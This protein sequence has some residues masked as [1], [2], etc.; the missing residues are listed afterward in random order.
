MV[1]RLIRTAL[2]AATFLVVSAAFVGA[3]QQVNQGSIAPG[4]T[5][6]GRLQSG[7]EH[8]YTIEIQEGGPVV[9]EMD[10]IDGSIDPYLELYTMNN[11]EIETNDDGGSGFNSQIVRNLGAG[12][13]RIVARE[14]GR[15]DSGRYRLAVNAQ[16]SGSTVTG[17][18]IEVGESL[19]SYINSGEPQRFLI[20]LSEAQR[21]QIDMERSDNSDIDPYLELADQYGIPITSN[22]DGGQGLNSRISTFLE[23]GQY[24]IIASDLGDRDTGGFRLIVVGEGSDPIDGIPIEVGQTLDS[25]IANGEQQY[26]VLELDSEETVQI[27]MLRDEAGSIDPY[28]VLAD[29]Y[30]SEIEYD[31]DGG[32]GF[33]S[34]IRRTLEAGRY[35]LIARDLGNR[36]SGPF[37]ISVTEGTRADTIPISVGQRYDGYLNP[38]QSYAYSLE[39][40]GTRTVTIEFRRTGS[41]DFDPYMV[42]SDALGN[43]ITSDDDS[44]GD[45]NSRIE[46]R[47][48][49]G[50][51]LIE[52][53]DVFDSNSGSFRISVE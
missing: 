44:G 27:D 25:H 1:V 14:F 46:R 19:S 47:L 8:V 35:T 36:R 40:Q 42:L 32:D 20:E 7:Q 53:S 52:V 13:Y 9:I 31:D 16:G 41:A 24:Q 37:Q 11:V 2:V 26:F 4:Q 51:Y 17:I 10:R 15:D 5:V 50:R 33:N 29:Q 38:G 34:R 45:L 18:P 43:R 49:A 28:L 23:R 39:L 12:R 3:Q 22:D 48:D 6:E 30:G 21:V